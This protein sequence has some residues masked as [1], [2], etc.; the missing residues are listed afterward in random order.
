MI[1]LNTTLAAVLVKT[2]APLQL[3]ELVIPEIGKGQTLVE[4]H[5]SGVCFT[6]VS[7]CRGHKGEDKF[8]PH[9]LGHEGS[10]VVLDVGEGVN[11]VKPGD[12]VVISWIKGSGADVPSARY[13]QNGKVINCGALATFNKHAVVSENRLTVVPEGVSM[14]DAAFV[15]CALPTGIGS[16]RNT[17]GAK[18]GQSIV[19]F[20]VGGV[21]LS[22][23][24]GAALVGCSPIIAVDIIEEKLAEAK[25][26]GATHILN[27]SRCD[28]VAEIKKICPQGSDLA[29]EATGNPKVILD[30]LE[31][32]K[33]QGGKTVVVGNPKATDQLT[34]SPKVFNAGKS[35]LGTWGGDT[36]PDVDFPYYFD[37]LSQKKIELSRIFSKTYSLNEINQAVDDLEQGKCI[38]PLIALK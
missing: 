23:V 21:G 11:K 29:V 33:N 27:A 17:L 2:G 14:R 22:S 18:K 12:R 25:R 28:V 30:S 5:F 35:I 15:G 20:G 16:V 9:C 3:M 6:Q 34:L 31:V 8:L 13:Q 1:K 10:G 32:L 19:I 26:L 4:L 24:M 38:R 37:L 7:E 36:K